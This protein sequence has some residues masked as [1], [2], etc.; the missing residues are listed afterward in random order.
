M[1]LLPRID[2]VPRAAVLLTKHRRYNAFLILLALL[3]IATAVWLWVDVILPSKIVETHTFLAIV[4]CVYVVGRTALGLTALLAIQRK[5]LSEA[6]A[7]D[8]GMHTRESIEALVREI[9]AHYRGRERAHVFVVNGPF[10]GEANAFTI[11]A[12]FLNWI[13]G[14]NAVYITRDLLHL[15]RPDEL[16]AIL[17]HE[18][19]HFHGLQHVL[20]RMIGTWSLCAMTFE[21]AVFASVPELVAAGW[22][23]Q[24]L[25]IIVMTLVLDSIFGVLVKRMGHAHEF[26]ADYEAARQFGHIPLVNALLRL[27][28]RG[29]IMIEVV[30]EALRTIRTNPKAQ[31]AKLLAECAEALPAGELPLSKARRLVRKTLEPYRGEHDVLAQDDSVGPAELQKL[32]RKLRKAL[33]VFESKRRWRKVDWRRFDVIRPDGELDREEIAPFIEALVAKPEAGVAYLPQ[34]Q[35]AVPPELLKRPTHPSFR[36]RILFLAREFMMGTALRKAD[37]S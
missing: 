21:L 5:R 13:H 27:A 30:Y 19:A 10:K 15:L 20:S 2:N 33:A 7:D 32:R 11:N 16:R 36:R 29:E 18:Y 17:A 14:L 37:A 28:M 4:V 24:L 35:R 23:A 8:L 22:L 12:L 6:T 1:P 26:L 34:E 31:M 25:A 9:E 3:F